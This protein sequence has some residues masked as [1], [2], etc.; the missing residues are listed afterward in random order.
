MSTSSLSGFRDTVTDASRRAM[1]R[2]QGL[3]TTATLADR[4]GET[5]RRDGELIA[6]VDSQGSRKRSYAQLNRDVIVLRQFLKM[7]GV[8]R[9]QVISVQLT[10]PL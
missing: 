5:A 2:S 9:G 8:S 10:Q 7:H 3:W 6:V 1:Y 4:V